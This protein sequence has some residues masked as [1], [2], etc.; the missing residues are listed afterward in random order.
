MNSEFIFDLLHKAV[1]EGEKLGADFVEARYDDYQLSSMNYTNEILKES[2]SKR[3]KG[4]GVMAYFE[5]T[6]GY[7]FTPEMNLEGIKEAT[8]RAVKL[9]LS[10]NPRNRMKLDFERRA[11][12]K[13][14]AIPKIK[15]HPKDYEIKDKLELLK[16][17]VAAIKENADVNLNYVLALLNSKTLDFYLKN[18]STPFRGGYY[19]YAKRFIER[20]P[21]FIPDPKSNKRNYYDQIIKLV[22][23]RFK[24]DNQKEIEQIENKI[25]III[26]D[27]YDLNKKEI[28]LIEK[29]FGG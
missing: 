7:S 13:D 1:K 22:E 24:S 20:L 5:G 18:I 4:M 26:Y 15:K 28:E 6:P 27:F 8:Q 29:K 12:I 11:A 17:G 14:K 25:N 21:I 3:R 16:R 9:A 23:K 19:S 2:S 10:T